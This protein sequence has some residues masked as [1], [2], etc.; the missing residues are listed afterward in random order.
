MGSNLNLQMK[1]FFYL[2]I[3]TYYFMIC[4]ENSISLAKTSFFFGGRGE[5]ISSIEH[6]ILSQ[7][8]HNKL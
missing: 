8:F 1:I 2:P 4:C 3:T 7:H 5:G 6:A